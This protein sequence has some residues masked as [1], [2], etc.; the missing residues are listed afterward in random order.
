MQKSELFEKIE[1]GTV[2]SEVQKQPYSFCELLYTDDEGNLWRGVGFAKVSGT[3]KWDVELGARIVNLRAK[4][5]V[6]QQMTGQAE[7]YTG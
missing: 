3:D 7:R 2:I 1:L 4:R 5:H 6:Y